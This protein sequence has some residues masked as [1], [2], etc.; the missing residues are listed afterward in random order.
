[1]IPWL[2]ICLF[3]YVHAMSQSMVDVDIDHLSIGFRTNLI[4]CYPS[5]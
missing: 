3:C 1:M 5:Y 2:A 4:P